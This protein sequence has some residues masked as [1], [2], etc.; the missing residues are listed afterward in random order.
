MTK[1]IEFQGQDCV[2]CNATGECPDCA[3]TGTV[4]DGRELR[5]LR[6]IYRISI[7]QMAK[8]C[9]VSVAQ[10]SMLENNKRKWKDDV[11]EKYT[12]YIEEVALQLV[13]DKGREEPA[14]DVRAQRIENMKKRAAEGGNP[15]DDIQDE[16][17]VNII[18]PIE[19]A[20]RQ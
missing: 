12:N 6:G 18:R 16:L 17:E 3:G 19:L 9:D 10:M 4:V 15:F 2:T 1:Q 14:Q 13:V 20:P 11:V 8:M 7:T 5:Y